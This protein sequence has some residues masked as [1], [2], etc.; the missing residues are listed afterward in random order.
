MYLVCETIWWIKLNS[1]KLESNIF[2]KKAGESRNI[3][4][5]L[6]PFSFSK[7]D[8]NKIRNYKQKKIELIIDKSIN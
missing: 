1:N 6:F 5:I 8:N 4:G 2:N 3:N 7:I